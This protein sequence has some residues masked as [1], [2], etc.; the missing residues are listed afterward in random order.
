MLLLDRSQLND[1]CDVMPSSSTT[2][3]P[4]PSSVMSFLRFSLSIKPFEGTN[5]TAA[6]AVPTSSVAEAFL[7][8]HHQTLS[9]LL[10]PRQ[11]PPPREAQD[12]GNVDV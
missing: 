12:N 11:S 10:L 3:S 1:D 7:A 6:T 9:L 2:L 5:P 8:A 4:S